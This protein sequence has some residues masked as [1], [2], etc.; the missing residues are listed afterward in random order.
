MWMSLV[1]ASALTACSAALPDDRSSVAATTVSVA[2]TVSVGPTSTVATTSAVT[3]PATGHVPPRVVLVGD[4]LALEAAPHLPALLPGQAFEH[5]TFGGTAPCDWLEA[6]IGYNDDSVVVFSFLGNASS[7]CMAPTGQMPRGDEIV[8]RYRSD[9]TALV[10]AA[11]AAGALVVLLGQPPVSPD[12]VDGNALVVLLNELYAELARAPDVSF[13]DAGAAL[14]S[15]QGAFAERLPCR[16][17]EPEC[18][19][20]GSIVVRSDDGVHF[21]PGTYVSP[22]PT[23]SSGAVRFA[24]AIAVAAHDPARFD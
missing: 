15:E 23:Y 16:A 18:G 12:N 3:S 4:S 1:A 8:E 2:S 11:I 24:E 13:V 7:A 19:A 21:C 20:D 6:D 9:V 5:H 22:C 17:D 14:E 10:A